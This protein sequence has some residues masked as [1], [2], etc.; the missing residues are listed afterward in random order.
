MFNAI[1][2]PLHN[3]FGI[4][5]ARIIAPGSAAEVFTA[6]PAAAKAAGRC[7]SWRRTS[8]MAAVKLSPSDC[9]GHRGGPKSP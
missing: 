9:R 8:S 6:S 4:E 5:N 2:P 7:R 1:M 3:K